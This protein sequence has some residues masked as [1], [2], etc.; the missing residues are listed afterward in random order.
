MRTEQIRAILALPGPKRYEHFIKQVADSQ[1]AWG[2]YKDGWALAASD[3]GT[4][5]LPLWPAEE[6]AALCAV[7]DWAGYVPSRIPLDELTTELLPG[8]ERDRI[9]PA[10]FFTPDDR[11][12]IPRI[13]ELLGDLDEELRHYE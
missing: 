11:G 2:L 8:L 7:S 3:D 6:Y 10:V 9:L 5:L 12:V 1:Q 13:E 4:P